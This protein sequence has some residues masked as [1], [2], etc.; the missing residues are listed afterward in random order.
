MPT[1]AKP[2]ESADE[3]P[4]T[5]LPVDADTIRATVVR[6]L[7][8][9]PVPRYD[10]LVGLEGLLRGH[11]QLLLPEAEKADAA[12]GLLTTVRAHLADGMGAGLVS[13]RI[14]VRQLAHDTRALLGWVETPR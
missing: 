11:L 12:S 6:A 13:A 8:Q 5:A 4:A 1:T 9:G 10:D 2:P 7:E 14:H 3:A